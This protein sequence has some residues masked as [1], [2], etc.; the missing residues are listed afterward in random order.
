M[1]MTLGHLIRNLGVLAAILAVMYLGICLLLFAS[2][3]SMIYQPQR[4]AVKD[5]SPTLML[6]VPGA[7]LQITV[8]P[9]PGPKALLYFGGNAENVSLSLAEFSQAFPDHA[10]F[11]MHYRGYEGSTGKPSEEAIR[12]DALALFDKVHEEYSDI[13]VM[14]RSLGS[15]VAVRVAS[16]RPVARLILITPY[17][18]IQDIAQDR[19]PYIPIRWLLLD[20][21]ES[22]RYASSIRTPTL[23]LAAANDEVIP[24]SSTVK[25][26]N[27]FPVGVASL[28][29]VPFFGHNDISTSAL[30]L[31]D[32]RA[33][34]TPATN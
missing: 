33:G 8:R 29:V 9:L 17:S 26:Y 34:L 7:D 1:A 20:K 24:R 13:A 30:Y 14:G 32:I 18:S 12:G 31:E 22:W 4:S 25:L 2:Q 21:F 3:R 28:K 5:S 19:F 27:A 23:L 11:L 15:G 6:Q 10:L 16:L